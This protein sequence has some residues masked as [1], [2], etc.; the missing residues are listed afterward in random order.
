LH[1]ATK[2]KQL[3]IEHKEQRTANLVFQTVHHAGCVMLQ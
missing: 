2:A 3:L 1:L